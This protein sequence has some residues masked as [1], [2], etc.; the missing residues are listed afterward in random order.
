MNAFQ[1]LDANTVTIQARGS[2]YTVMRHNGGFRVYC[3]NAS[4]LAYRRGFPVGRQFATLAA[5]EQA[6]KGLRGVTGAFEVA[7]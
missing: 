7:A 2:E 3:V 1:I 5:V 6:Y 4:S